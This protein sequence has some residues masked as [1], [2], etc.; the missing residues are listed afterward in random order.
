MRVFRV[1][2]C[3]VHT[4]RLRHL[5]LP[6]QRCALSGRRQ[7]TQKRRRLRARTYFVLFTKRQSVSIDLPHPSSRKLL[8]AFTGDLTEEGGRVQF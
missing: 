3:G 7:H 6:E 4:Y 5:K 8:N 1:V 2:E